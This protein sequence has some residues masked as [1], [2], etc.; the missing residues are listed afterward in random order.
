MFSS[1]ADLL[2]FLYHVWYG[3]LETITHVCA[4]ATKRWHAVKNSDVVTF[5]SSIPIYMLS[6]K[7]LNDYEGG[8]RQIIA[9]MTTILDSK[10]FFDFFA[11]LKFHEIKNQTRN[12]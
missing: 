4:V 9:S 3:D 11:T 7:Y 6:K 5:E 8:A 1:G 2:S 10:F 12:W